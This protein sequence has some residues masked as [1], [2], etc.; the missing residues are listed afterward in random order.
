M[1]DN[2]GS[3]LCR[4]ACLLGIHGQFGCASEKKLA[5]SGSLGYCGSKDLG[6]D[7]SFVWLRDEG[8]VHSHFECL[9][10][11]FM[12]VVHTLSCFELLAK[13]GPASAIS[14]GSNRIVRGV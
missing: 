9:F 4:V 6:S 11:C 10:G 3:L 13:R 8:S 1:R 14:R 5:Q 7:F 12:A 2:L